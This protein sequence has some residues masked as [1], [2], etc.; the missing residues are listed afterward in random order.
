VYKDRNICNITIYF[1]NIH[2][3]NLQ[4]IS[5]TSETLEMYACN[6]RFSSFFRVTQSRA[7]NDWFWPPAAEDGGAA[8]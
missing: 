2:L 5:E 3:K 4:H 1:G 8:W 7:G 6:M